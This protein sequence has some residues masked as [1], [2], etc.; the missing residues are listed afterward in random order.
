MNCN[1]LPGCLGALDGT[2]IPVHVSAIDRPR[3]RTRKNHI[4][5]NVLA[6][7]TPDLHFTCVLPV[8]EGSVADGQVLWDAIARRHGLV[9]PRCKTQW[10]YKINN[11]FIFRKIL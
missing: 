8:W 11:H 7:C 5:T 4:A 1:V 9:V 3:Y 6:A 10:Y 2:H